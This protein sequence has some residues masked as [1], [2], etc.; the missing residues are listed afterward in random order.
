MSLWLAYWI[1]AASG[2]VIGMFL[3]SVLGGNDRG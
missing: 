2:L 1:G 3:Y